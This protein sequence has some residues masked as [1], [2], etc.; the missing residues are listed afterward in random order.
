MATVAH[1]WDPQ[2]YE[3][4]HSF[5]WNYGRG[6]IDLLAP[7][8]GERI[9][10][11]GCGTGQLTSEIAS[12][13]AETLGIDASPDMIGQAR[14]N[15]PSRN[16]PQL[17][18]ALV[19]AAQMPF[20]AEFDAVF[21]N[22]ALHW[23]LDTEAVVKAIAH[24]LK[25]FGRLVLECGGKGNV[26]RIEATISKVFSQSLHRPLPPSRTIFH[27][28]SSFTALLESNGLETR[29][30]TLFDRPTP[31]EGDRGMHRWLEQF[32]AYYFEALPA[33]ERAQALEEVV[34]ELRPHLFHDDV[35]KADYRRLR[36]IAHRLP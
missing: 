8:S 36:V 12:L 29:M 24:A 27:S 13:G 6:L 17:K 2:L 33:A 10:D 31:L 22:A 34:A 26:G 9:L 25:P 11:V 5:V 15:F 1:H 32:S 14:Q 7:K 3:A 28:V 19:D 30:A 4:Q 35:W 23:M 21:S 18:F 16:R 20:D